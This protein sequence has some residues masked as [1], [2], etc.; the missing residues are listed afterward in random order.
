MA[1]ASVHILIPEICENVWFHNKEDI[2]VASGTE[3]GSKVTI[4]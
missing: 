2:K 1:P 3:V 4:K